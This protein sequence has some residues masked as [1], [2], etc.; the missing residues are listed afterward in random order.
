MHEVRRRGRG[1]RQGAAPGG[2]DFP[3]PRF[4]HGPSPR[5]IGHSAARDHKNTG[6]EVRPT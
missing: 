2:T 5:S 4:S 1:F 6:R 3:K